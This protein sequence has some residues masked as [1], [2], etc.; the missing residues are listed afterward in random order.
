MATF[1]PI[2]PINAV[3]MCGEG[4]ERSAR[5]LES[6]RSSRQ[7]VTLSGSVSVFTLVRGHFVHWWTLARSAPLSARGHY[8]DSIS[9]EFP[10]LGLQSQGSTGAPR[11]RSYL[12]HGRASVLAQ[13]LC[14]RRSSWCRSSQ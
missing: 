14:R 1:S 6:S 8:K 3:S 5:S 4:D 2:A 7:G 13:S 12:E 11:F 10:L 9:R